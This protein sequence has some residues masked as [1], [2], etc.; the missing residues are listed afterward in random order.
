[1]SSNFCY[2]QLESGQAQHFVGPGLD[3]TVCKSYWYMT[4]SGQE[5]IVLLKV[6][7]EF[8]K[9]LLRSFMQVKA[10]MSSHIYIYI[11]F[12]LSVLIGPILKI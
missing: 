7:T 11:F 8:L 12:N 10:L 1:M 2:A 3:L 6:V 4:L 5:L 9:L